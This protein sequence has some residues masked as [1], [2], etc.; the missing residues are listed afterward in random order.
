MEFEC[1]SGQE[2]WKG[3]IYNFTKRDNIYEFWIQSKTD[4]MVIIGPTSRGGFACFPDL[5]ASCHLTS[6]KNKYWNAEQ[7]TETLG[8][9]N[10]LTVSSA[11]IKLSETVPHI[12]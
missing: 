3:V 4:I 9:V 12:F 2:A 1:K 6:L 11:L 10:G 8:K 7:L 5:R